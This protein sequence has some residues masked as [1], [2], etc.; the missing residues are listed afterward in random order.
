MSSLFGTAKERQL[1]NKKIFQSKEHFN[2]VVTVK[3]SSTLFKCITF[4]LETCLF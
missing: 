1:Q 3:I 4:K 2:L